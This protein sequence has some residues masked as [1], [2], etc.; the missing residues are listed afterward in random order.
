MF[1]FSRAFTSNAVL[2][3]VEYICTMRYAGQYDIMW[4]KEQKKS[5]INNTA[6]NWILGQTYGPE[7]KNVT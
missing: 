4:N 2:T 1:L 5:Q 7:D 3:Q 6:T